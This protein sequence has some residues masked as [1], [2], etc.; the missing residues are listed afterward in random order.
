[1][2]RS[3]AT[4]TLIARL[5]SGEGVGMR[6][7]ESVGS[8]EPHLVVAAVGCVRDGEFTLAD[9]VVGHVLGVVDA[10]E[11]LVGEGIVRVVRR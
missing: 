2:A 5:K 11:E 7:L 1:M 8:A 4:R 10:T 9:G 3:K 6:G